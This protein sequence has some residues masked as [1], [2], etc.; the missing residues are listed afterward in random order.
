VLT[1]PASHSDIELASGRQFIGSLP[2]I[3]ECADPLSA[4]P[5]GTSYGFLD[6]I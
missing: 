2:S 6:V 5:V 3:E 1:L 4:T